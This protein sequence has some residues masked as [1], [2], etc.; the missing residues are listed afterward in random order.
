M[1]YQCYGKV[2]RVGGRPLPVMTQIL[3]VTD[4]HMLASSKRNSG[5][6][7]EYAKQRMGE[8]SMYRRCM[9]EWGCASVHVC[10]YMSVCICVFVNTVQL[11]DNTVVWY[12]MVCE[13]CKVSAI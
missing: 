11:C 3:S 4:R 2:P 12:V 5:I 8:V 6:R 1:C 10:M 9:T 13:R 7:I